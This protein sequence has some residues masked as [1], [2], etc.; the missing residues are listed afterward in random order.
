MGRA[1]F[2]LSSKHATSFTHIESLLYAY[3][4]GNTGRVGLSLSIHLSVDTQN[5][6]CSDPD[7]NCLVRASFCY[8]QILHFELSSWAHL[9]TTPKYLATCTT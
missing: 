3:A 2:S 9:S 1:N 4:R 7:N 8:I 5:G 6:S